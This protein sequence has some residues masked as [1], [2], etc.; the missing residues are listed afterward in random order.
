M[1]DL[2]AA[3][4]QIMDEVDLSGVVRI[5][6]AGS[7][8]ADSMLVGLARGFADRAHGIA[9]TI[10]TRFG[11]ASGTKGFTALVVMKL[12][13]HDALTLDT[14]ARS[15]LGS[16]LPLIDDRVTI[17]HLLAHRSGIGDYLD[18]DVETDRDAYLM[19]VP[20][21]DLVD[22]SAFLS[23]L[24]GHP[25]KFAPDTRFSYCNG[26]FVVLALIV[27]RVSGRGYHELVDELVFRPARMVGSAF[28][29]SDA[30]PARAARGYLHDD[31]TQP[32]EVRLQTNV[33][34]LPVRGNG[35][36]G[37]YSPAADLQSFWSALFAGDVVSLD[38]L[39]DMIRPR[40]ADLEDSAAYGLG[41]WLDEP[42][43]AVSIHGF[44]TGVGFVSVHDPARRLTYTVLSNQSRGAWPCSQRIGELLADA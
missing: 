15:I 43:G 39:A 41:F 16:D 42:S 19:P 5:D 6:R 3:V 20:V 24:G 11:L 38:T 40:S 4:Q 13:E 32:D 2:S 26:A 8:V 37:S 21:Q 30:L 44:D 22:T 29:R 17:E 23:V 34:H 10:D 31:D 12:V 25:T 9:N 1:N 35:D 14:T 28:L 33:F 36:G 18:E 27:E 7:T